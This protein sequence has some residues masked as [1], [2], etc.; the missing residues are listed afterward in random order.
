M[1]NTPFGS[2]PR[3]DGWRIRTAS[4]QA[5][6][7]C[8]TTLPGVLAALRGIEALRGA[9]GE[10]RSIQEL[11]ELR[12]HPD[13]GAGTP[14]T[15][16][17]PRAW[18]REARSRRGPEH[19]PGWRLPLDHDRRAGGGR[20]GPA[21]AV[22]LGRD[23]RGTRVPA[24][25]SRS[26]S[27][28]VAAR[29]VGGDAGVRVRHLGTGDRV[30]LRGEGARVPGRHRPARQGVRVP[31]QAQ[32]LPARVRGP[33]VGPDVLPRPGAPRSRQTGRHGGRRGRRTTGCSS[34][35]K[36][37]ACPRRSR[38]P[39]RTGA[40]ASEGA[41]WTRSP[42]WWSRRARRSS[43]RPGAARRSDASPS[44]AWTAASRRR[45]RSRRRWRAASACASRAR[46]RSFARTDRASTTSV[47]ARM[48]PCS[49][50]RG[51]CGTDGSEM[52]LG[53]R[54]RRPKGFP[55]VDS[56]PG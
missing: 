25:P 10:P 7:P 23:A 18:V 39:P 42:R 26:R 38:S 36:A 34:R 31:R 3:S 27:T 56:W 28:G 45:S 2:G 13:A 22:R 8:I 9:W 21:G 17:T 53:W 20:P 11:H 24:P 30:A 50:R 19:A 29:R 47:R 49:T 1:I 6:I 32:H 40:S 12:A 48:A 43:T 51:S 44:S 55:V 15:R 41:C 54:R 52:S 5:G 35:S 33:W 14:A 46:C 4:A 16:S 37:S